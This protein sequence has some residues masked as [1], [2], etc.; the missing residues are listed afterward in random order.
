VAPWNFVDE[1]TGDL[2][3]PSRVNVTDITLSRY[4][5]TAAV[6]FSKDD[7]KA[8]LR[9]LDE[10][11]IPIAEISPFY[12]ES[13]AEEF[14]EF[15]E[16]GLDLEL[17]VLI[18]YIHGVSYERQIDLAAAVG[19]DYVTMTTGPMPSWDKSHRGKEVGASEAEVIESRVK[20]INYA[21]QKGLKVR[22]G[23]QFVTYLD[24][25]GFMERLF[26]AEA[27]AG[28]DCLVISDHG[29]FSPPALRYL[30]KRAK[31]AAP[32]TAIGMHYHDTLGHGIACNLAAVEGGAELV[33]VTINGVG[34][35][36][37]TDLAQMVL[38]LEAL[39]G[40]TTGV[41]LPGIIGLY[42][43]FAELSGHEIW[44]HKPIVGEN[45]YEI[46]SDLVSRTTMIDYDPYISTV[47][48]PE[49][50]GG[51]TPFEFGIDSGPIVLQ[52]RAAEMGV[53][54]DE[55]LVMPLVQAL[56][57]DIKTRKSRISDARLIELIAEE[58]S[59]VQ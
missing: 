19:L 20:I 47:M 8:L 35:E 13:D 23:I 46:S 22:G 14:K 37:H 54:L 49:T 11:K 10:V 4:S 39:Y 55:E 33:E 26:K 53:E 28:A 56:R 15:V 9:A 52:R 48:T 24:D 18:G 29:G 6:Y 16:L 3:T 1:V 7:K 40:V 5:Q 36:G 45:F 12:N 44:Q 25:L 27:D 50:V 32:N 41:E 38:C 42:K 34:G 59:K 43:R 30:V 57:E 58:K 31:A 17:S 51:R 2:A 21:K